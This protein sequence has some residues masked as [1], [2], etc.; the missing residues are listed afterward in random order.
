M[1]VDS[2]DVVVPFVLNAKP[3]MLGG[4][5]TGREDMR[6]HPNGIIH[7]PILSISIFE[8]FF[9]FLSLYYLLIY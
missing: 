1:S 8:V 2:F 7:S 5:S 9:F 6:A 3:V 4:S